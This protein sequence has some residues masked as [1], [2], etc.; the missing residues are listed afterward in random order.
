MIPLKDDIPARHPPV[1]TFLAIAAAALAYLVAGDQLGV[2]GG[3]WTL[4]VGGRV[5][6][7]VRPVGGGRDGPRAVR[8]V[9]AWPA[10]R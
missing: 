7:A 1:V 9:P 2:D 3:G 6:V 5:P 10:A 8:R 4:L